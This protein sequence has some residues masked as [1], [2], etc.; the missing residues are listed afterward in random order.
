MR[1]IVRMAATA[2][3]AAATCFGA[4]A[5]TAP[6]QNAAVQ[7]PAV[8]TT[9]GGPWL[10]AGAVEINYGICLFDPLPSSLPL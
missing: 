8:S 1:V 4:L 10:C 3:A 7:A 9:N 2:A 6:A 5:L